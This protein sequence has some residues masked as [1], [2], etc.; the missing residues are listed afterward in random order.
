MILD[1]P[2]GNVTLYLKQKN[3]SKGC[4]VFKHYIL[5]YT[6]EDPDTGNRAITPAV[7]RLVRV[8]NF[9]TFVCKC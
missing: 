2:I 6:I 1:I 3:L 7:T 8:K 5:Y 4:Q 9:N